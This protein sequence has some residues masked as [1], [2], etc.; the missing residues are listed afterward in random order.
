M[1]IN[2]PF[3]CIPAWRLPVYELCLCNWS[4]WLYLDVVQVV[5][6]IESTCLY[7]YSEYYST[8]FGSAY[9][10]IA[11]LTHCFFFTPLCLPYMKASIKDCCY[12]NNFYIMFES[13]ITF[14]CLMCWV[15]FVSHLRLI[16]YYTVF[17]MIDIH[18]NILVENCQLEQVKKYR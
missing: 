2:I 10:N 11:V 15:F 12:K 13:Y 17:N 7:F 5:C 8:K 6:R 4:H 1:S 14:Y 3:Q 16:S 18:S 9:L